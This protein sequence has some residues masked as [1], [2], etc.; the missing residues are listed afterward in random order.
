VILELIGEAFFDLAMSFNALVCNLN[1]TV[2]LLTRA[3]L[4][5]K[6]KGFGFG[7]LVPSYSGLIKALGLGFISYISSLKI[8]L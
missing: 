6:L 8:F 2:L 4:S 3:T 7:S 5:G 1:S